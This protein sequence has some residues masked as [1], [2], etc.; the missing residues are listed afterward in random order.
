MTTDRERVRS[1]EE[2]LDHGIDVSDG[3]PPSRR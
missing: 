1:S 3:R 2:V